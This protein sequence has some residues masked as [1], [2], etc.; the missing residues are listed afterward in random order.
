MCDAGQSLYTINSCALGQYGTS[1][2]A[3]DFRDRRP[4]VYFVSCPIQV[5]EAAVDANVDVLVL[6]DTNG[7]SLPWEVNMLPPLVLLKATNHNQRTH[8]P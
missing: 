2:L 7:G 3:P 1:D 4:L 5:C 6:C 8:A